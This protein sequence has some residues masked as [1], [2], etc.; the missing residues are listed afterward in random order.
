MLALPSF[1]DKGA[2]IDGPQLVVPV[3]VDGDEEV[4]GQ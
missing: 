4:P 1:P 2:V 3:V